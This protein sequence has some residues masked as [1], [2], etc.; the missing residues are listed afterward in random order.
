[1][2]KIAILSH[3]PASGG[4]G[5]AYLS[6]VK[7]ALS[8]NFQTDNVNLLSGGELPL[9]LKLPKAAAGLWKFSRSAN[10]DTVIRSMDYCV[11]LNKKPIKN[12]AIVHHIDY[13]FTPALIKF[14]S[15]FSTPLILRNLRKADAI[16]VVSKYWERYLKEK[17]YSNVYLIY[18]GFDAD[19]FNFSAEE[20]EKFRER[21]GL[22]G[23]PIVYLG[24]RNKAKGVVESYA[25]LKDIDAHLVTSGSPQAEIPA[26][27]LE[28]EYEDY[29]KL[30]STSSVVIAMSRFKEGWCRT[31]HEAMLLKTPVIGSGTG[32]MKE[33]LE[34]GNQ[35]IC[36]D[37]GALR[38]KVE[39]F[40][41]N[42]AYRKSLGEKGH[43]FAKQ[44]TKE[45]FEREWLKLIQ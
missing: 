25:A 28:L 33:L 37:F 7:D 18:N 45:R 34:G 17:G 43:K 30:L 27:N 14:I 13:S 6:M 40:L 9:Y 12:I 8:Q 2:K 3:K 29:L 31:A 42:E 19:K 4:G 39:G 20:I 36:E 26:K 1:M 41:N 44:F 5:S 24:N 11:L 35:V 23:K 15:F 22:L 10:Y 32:G 16:V 38:E 21:H